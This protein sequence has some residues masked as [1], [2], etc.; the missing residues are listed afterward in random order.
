[1]HMWK[2]TLIFTL[3]SIISLCRSILY[4]FPSAQR[5]SF[6]TFCNAYLVPMSSL[7]FVCKTLFFFCFYFYKQNPQFTDIFLQHFKIIAPLSP[8]LI[9]SW[10]EGCYL[11]QLGSSLHNVSCLS[12]FKTFSLA[13][14]FSNLNMLWL[15]AF[16][17][18][19]SA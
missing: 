7:R 1:M 15:S 2:E 5:T 16:L 14:M 4:Y 13:L 18:I 10:Q 6:T 8:S 19:S 12:E 11:S 3:I 9:S 17:Y